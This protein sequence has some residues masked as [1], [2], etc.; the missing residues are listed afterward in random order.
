MHH[1]VGPTCTT[2]R[3]YEMQLGLGTP[4]PLPYPISTH[5]GDQHYNQL[6][7][8][9]PYT[10]QLHQVRWHTRFHT[11]FDQQENFWISTLHAPFHLF[12][13][14]SNL[15]PLTEITPKTYNNDHLSPQILASSTPIP[16]NT[17]VWVPPPYNQNKSI[18]HRSGKNQNFWTH[19]L[20]N[21]G[22][23]FNSKTYQFQD[24]HH[25]HI[26]ISSFH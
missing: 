26:M 2:S 24:H 19:I 21:L 9:L 4:L 16:P 14:I 7:W 8:G 1:L 23:L 5:P 25:R 22:L 17:N 11:K 6:Q 20:K 10:P 13:T 15:V 12:L 18:P 3:L